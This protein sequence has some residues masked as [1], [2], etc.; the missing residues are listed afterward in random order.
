[1]DSLKSMID[2]HKPIEPPQVAALKKYALNTYGV[3]IEVKVSS[4]H[5]LVRVPGASLAQKFRFESAKITAECN[6]DKKLV[7]HIG[8]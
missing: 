8:H 6:L 4:N 1:M 2:K 3:F 5:Y 7:I